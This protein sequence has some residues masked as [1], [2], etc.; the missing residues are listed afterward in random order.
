[1]KDESISAIFVAHD[2]SSEETKQ[3]TRRLF[4]T[5]NKKAKRV[6]KSAIIALDEDNGF[7]VITRSLIDEHWLFERGGSV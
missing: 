6:S 7:A 2:A 5:V 3:R 1:M 4:T